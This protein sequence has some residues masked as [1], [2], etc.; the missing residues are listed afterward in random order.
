CELSG[1]EWVSPYD[2]ERFTDRR[3]LQIDDLVALKG[4][5]ESGAWEWESERLVEFGSFLDDP[6]HLVAVS[7]PSNQAK[8][9]ADPAEW[10]P[11]SEHYV[12]RYLADWVGVKLRWELTADEREMRALRS[13]AE[14]GSGD[15]GREPVRAG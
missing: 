11:P 3:D 9:H 14:A 5:W 2:G 13:F 4:A 12:C 6:G 1:G 10:L 7:G 15:C 8:G